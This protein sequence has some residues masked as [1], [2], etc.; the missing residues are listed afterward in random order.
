MTY[1]KH[2]EKA[3]RAGENAARVAR[4]LAVFED[5]SEWEYTGEVSETPGRA[6]TCVC[7]C[8]ITYNFHWVRPR[9]GRKA[10]TGSVCVKNVPGMTADLLA[11]LAESEA[12]HKAAAAE[13]KKAAKKAAET[14]EIG[15]LRAEAEEAIRAFWEPFRAEWERLGHPGWLPPAIYHAHERRRVLR[16]L[17]WRSATLKTV[18][19]QRR[20]LREAIE[21]ARKWAEKK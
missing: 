19:G 12:A 9:D 7:G 20:I 3:D 11:R 1:E 18:A 4:I 6:G 13:A 15:S 8:K 5:V 2:E 17:L 14:A 10:I 16:G 21:A